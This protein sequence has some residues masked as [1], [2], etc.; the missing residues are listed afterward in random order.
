MRNEFLAA[1]GFVPYAAITGAAVSVLDVLSSLVN[2]PNNRRKS[3]LGLNYRGLATLKWVVVWTIGTA[4]GGFVGLLAQVLQ[5][6][7]NA[8][9]VVAVTWPFLLRQITQRLQE[10]EPEQADKS[11]DA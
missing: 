7:V 9:I 6:T 4:L 5:P 3:F 1:F 2:P 10:N 11:N 8:A